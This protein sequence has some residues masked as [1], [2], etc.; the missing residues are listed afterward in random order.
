[1]SIFSL[2]TLESTE[3]GTISFIKF[4][5]V[6]IQAFLLFLCNYDFC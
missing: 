6:M 4:V 5:M 3:F 2:Y 1:M